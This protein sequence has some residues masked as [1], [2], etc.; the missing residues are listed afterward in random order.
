MEYFIVVLFICLIV[1]LFCLH[2]LSRD[3]LIFLRKDVS[4][5]RI[6]NFSFVT[7]F[8]GLFFARFFY[9]IFNNAGMLTKPLVF[10]LFPYF[11]GL[12][13]TGGILGGTL[14]LLYF[15]RT[16]NMLVERIFDFFSISVLASLP[17][18][19]LGYFLFMLPKKFSLE[20]LILIVIY[21]ILFFVFIKILCFDFLFKGK[22]RD[23]SI[24]LLF[25]ALFSL[26]S[27]IVNTVDQFKDQKF[28]DYPENYILLG[29]F[30][31]AVVL[32]IDKENLLEKIAKRRK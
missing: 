10:F 28:I 4:L 21:A 20:I 27:L 22:L 26:I 8:V 14:F 6:F 25:I 5:E 32:L 30:L 15:L 16:K 2:F 19:Y 9:A 31:I 11:P 1:S 18:G 23:G 3:D 24:G 29:A 13:L 7:F 17:I 12:S